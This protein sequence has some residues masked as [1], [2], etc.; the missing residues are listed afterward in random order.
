MAV[1]AL[2]LPS[3]AQCFNPEREAALE[4]LFEKIPGN[5]DFLEQ[6]KDDPNFVA[7]KS[8][9]GLTCQKSQ[10]NSTPSIHCSLARPLSN[11][12][13]ETLFALLNE[14]YLQIS[15]PLPSVVLSDVLDPEL[16]PGKLSK[17]DST[18][19]ANRVREYLLKHYSNRTPPKNYVNKLETLALKVGSLACTRKRW[20]VY[21]GNDVSQDV[22]KA[23][24]VCKID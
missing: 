13:Q 20:I 7:Q 4:V 24:Y 3:G 8:A 18:S 9:S 12:Q 21:Q 5:T 10:L 1:S 11:A 23:T 19:L 16:A 17:P 14:V 15:L 2:I 22:S 6:F